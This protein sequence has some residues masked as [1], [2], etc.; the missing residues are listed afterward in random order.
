MELSRNA[1]C[2]M[3]DTFARV[4]ERQEMEL[5]P[6]EGVKVAVSLGQWV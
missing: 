4:D 5:E 6:I 1:L 2:T 3:V